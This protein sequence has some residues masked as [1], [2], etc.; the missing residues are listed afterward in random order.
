MHAPAQLRL[1]ANAYS[2]CGVLGHL[3][4]VASLESFSFG[5][6]R[7]GI[8]RGNSADQSYYVHVSEGMLA[9]SK[10]CCSSVGWAAASLARVSELGTIV[11]FML[12]I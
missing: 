12:A 6:S 10:G 4:C 8:K 5:L 2:A 7:V 11:T 1:N 9:C 3:G